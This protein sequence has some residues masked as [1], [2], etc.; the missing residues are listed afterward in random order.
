MGVFAAGALLCAGAV[1]AALLASPAFSEVARPP[2][3]SRPSSGPAWTRPLEAMDEAVAEGKQSSKYIDTD[4]NIENI[5]AATWKEIRLRQGRRYCSRDEGWQP[6]KHPT[7]KR[8]ALHKKLASTK[9][10]EEVTDQVLYAPSFDAWDSS[11]LATAWHRL[12]KLANRPELQGWAGA[13]GRTKVLDVRKAHEIL[14]KVVAERDMSE[15][16]AMELSMM[17]YAYGKLGAG[18]DSRGVRRCIR[19]MLKGAVP[20]IDEFEPQSLSM[21]M[22]A[23]GR[24]KYKDDNVYPTILSAVFRRINDF[25]ASQL[26]FTAVAMRRL[27]LVE[28]PVLRA[29]C[30]RVPDMIDEFP[31]RNIPSMLYAIGGLEYRHRGFLTSVTEHI[32]GHLADYSAP[33]LVLICRALAR[34]RFRHKPFM[35]AIAEHVP[36]RINEFRSRGNALQNLADAMRELQKPKRK[37]SEPID[38]NARRSSLEQYDEMSGAGAWR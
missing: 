10:L 5:Q 8:N 38:L 34:L 26:A 28:K 13:Q 25:E 29:I 24:R 7:A 2:L 1:G 36:R 16:N 12:A 3:N 6:F 37:E 15:F 9:I 32:T 33:Q 23:L 31:A 30:D 21:L 19:K 18:N 17:I 11:H 4:S 14:A 35:I 20:R 27:D 22:M